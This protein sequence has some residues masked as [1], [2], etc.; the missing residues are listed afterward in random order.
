MLLQ[1]KRNLIRR[2]YSNAVI[3]RQIKSIK[4]S[5]RAQSLRKKK[6][7]QVNNMATTQKLPKP[8]YTARYCPITGKAFRIVCKHWSNITTNSTILKRLLANTPRLAYKANYNLSKKL[9]RAKL[10]DS[11]SDTQSLLEHSSS[12]HSTN[13]NDNS[14]SNMHITKLANLKHQI[15]KWHERGTISQCPDRLCPL[16]NKL[17]H[18]SQVRSRT[19]RRTFH[20]HGKADCN[21]RHVVYLIECKKCKRQYVGQTSL[22]LK[23]RLAKHITQVRNHKIASTVHEHFRPG[24][25]CQGLHNIG[26]QPLHVVTPTDTAEVAQIEQNLKDLETLWIKRL[27]C[28]Y[29]QGLN[30]ID[31]DPRT[32]YSH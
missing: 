27:M 28:E 20:T 25:R 31:K 18:R 12:E 24:Q 3:N 11:Q 30:W 2:G 19:S 6:P 32:R 21:T 22:S 14:N 17:M 9:V 8:T 26:L 16:H 5:M 15:P 7:K 13:S 29:P 23:K 1:H 10:K 4:F